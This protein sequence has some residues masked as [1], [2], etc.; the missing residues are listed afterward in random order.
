M[1]SKGITRNLVSF[2]V[3]NHGDPSR[4]VNAESCAPE[5]LISIPNAAQDLVFIASGV[6]VHF[7]Q[8]ALCHLTRSVFL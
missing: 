4:C 6:Q 1:S 2:Q 5:I 8:L 3:L 7:P